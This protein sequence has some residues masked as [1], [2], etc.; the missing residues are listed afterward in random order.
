MHAPLERARTEDD[1]RQTRRRAEA[2][3][4]AAVARVDAP[5]ADV[6]RMPAERRDRVDDRQRAVLARDR[7]EL[8]RPDSARRSTF[9]RA[10]CATMSAGVAFRARAQRVG[11]AG[12]APLDVEPRHRRAVALAHLRQP[13]AEVAGDDDERRACPRST[14]FATA[15]SMPDVPVPDT[16]NANDPSGARNIRASRARTSSSSAIISGSRWLTRRRRHRAHHAR[17]GQAR[18]GPEQD[19]IGVGQQAHAGISSNAGQRVAQR[20]DRRVGHG[21]SGGRG[22]PTS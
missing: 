14:R 19:A 12:A 9:P 22:T 1:R 3:L 21:R 17:R 20:G 13:I 15:V 16:A 7:R 6:E 4:R 8:A 5:R 2:F 10:P 18:P 11:I